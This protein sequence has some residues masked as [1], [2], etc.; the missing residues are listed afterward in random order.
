MDQVNP[1][2]PKNLTS[3]LGNLGWVPGHW[4]NPNTAEEANNEEGEK[5]VEVVNKTKKSDTSAITQ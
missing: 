4:H 1:E 2:D 5:E 3:T